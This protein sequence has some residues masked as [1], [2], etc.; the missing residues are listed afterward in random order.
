MRLVVAGVPAVKQPIRGYI[1]ALQKVLYKV[2]QK[3]NDK[4]QFLSVLQ[5]IHSPML[6]YSACCA[7]I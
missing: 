1:M 4:E 2:K 6:F 5:C 3:Q 7:Y